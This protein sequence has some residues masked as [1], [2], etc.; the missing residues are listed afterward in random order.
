MSLVLITRQKLDIFDDRK[1][2]IYKGWMIFGGM[3]LLQSLIKHVSWLIFFLI[4]SSTHTETNSHMIQHLPLNR[5]CHSPC[6]YALASPHGAS[7]SISI[8]LVRDSWW[9][10]WHWSRVSSESLWIS[11]LIN[12]QTFFHIF[13]PPPFL[14]CTKP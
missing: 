3:M 8:N 6:S 12:I 5:S 11:P 4:G 14:R 7:G 2:K 1:L 10:K 9:N 13:A